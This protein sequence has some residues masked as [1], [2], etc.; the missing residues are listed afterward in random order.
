MNRFYRIATLIVPSTV[1]AL[2]ILGTHKQEA[3]THSTAPFLAGLWSIMMSLLLIRAI[4]AKRHGAE[5]FRQM[6][7]LTG[8]GRATMWTGA[9]A[10]VGALVSGWASLSVLGVLGL[11]CVYIAAIWTTI[12]AGGV[13]PWRAAKVT[14]AIM[15]ELATE[16]DIL[17]EELHLDG[18][19][20]PAGMRLFATGRAMPEGPTTR[21]AIGSEC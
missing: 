17:L 15:P 2:V 4:E 12:V 3:I 21:Y 8:A 14:R 1:A 13:R 16:G 7:V 20:I 11:G 18:I 5:A 9:A 19:K 6:D 10:I